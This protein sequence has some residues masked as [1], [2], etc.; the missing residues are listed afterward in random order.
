MDLLKGVVAGLGDLAT[1]HV[2][3]DA[4]H[5]LKVPAK[6]GCTPAQAEAE[7]LDA[8]LHLLKRHVPYFESDHV[9]N[10]AY[11]FL[12]VALQYATLGTLPKLDELGR[13]LL[14]ATPQL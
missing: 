8:R 6:S 2:V 4:D 5:S 9:L 11:N 1:L 13:P 14:R 10:L 3:A 12:G 7:A